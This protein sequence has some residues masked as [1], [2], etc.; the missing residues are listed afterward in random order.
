MVTIWFKGSTIKYTLTKPGCGGVV[1]GGTTTTGSATSEVGLLSIGAVAGF[2]EGRMA[3]LVVVMRGAE[4]GTVD[5]L[6]VDEFDDEEDDE[7]SMGVGSKLSQIQEM[8]RVIELFIAAKGFS[9]VINER[10][11]FVISSSLSNRSPE[12]RPP[13]EVSDFQSLL[14][15]LVVRVSG[16]LLNILSCGRGLQIVICCVEGSFAVANVLVLALHKQ[17]RA[18][19]HRKYWQEICVEAT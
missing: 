6:L 12:G 13:V 17:E 16:V 8:S 3:L 5:A 9:S 15:E 11:S 7:Y 10:Y 18:R 2:H 4:V 19:N 14:R 1:N